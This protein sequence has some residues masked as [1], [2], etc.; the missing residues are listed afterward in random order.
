MLVPRG[1]VINFQ[2]QYKQLA[3]LI[4]TESFNEQTDNCHNTRLG[5]A[6]KRMYDSHELCVFDLNK[7]REVLEQ[8]VQNEDVNGKLKD[9]C[10][11]MLNCLAR[12]IE[13]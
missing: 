3:L 11:F 7:I 10:S 9:E 13:K 8:F 5:E 4:D 12:A 6:K 2:E 1:R